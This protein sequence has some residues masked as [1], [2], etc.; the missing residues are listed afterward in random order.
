MYHTVLCMTYVK[1]MKN[2]EKNDCT[3]KKGLLYYYYLFM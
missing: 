2:K 1:T 3:T